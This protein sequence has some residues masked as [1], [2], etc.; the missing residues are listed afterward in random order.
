MKQ[1]VNDI[2]LFIGSN[3]VD[4][5]YLGTDLVYDANPGPPYDAQVEYLQGDGSAYIDTNIAVKDATRVEILFYSPTGSSKT[6]FGNTTTSTS[7]GYPASVWVEGGGVKYYAVGQSA[8]KLGDLNTDVSADFTIPTNAVT[9]S[10]YMF[11]ANNYLGHNG[12]KCYRCKLYNGSE[13]IRDF[14]PVRKD[15]VGYMYDNVSGRLFGNV[16][17]GSFTYGNDV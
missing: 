3:A 17:T 8:V 13:L 6:V 10:I 12:F 14:I 7:S 2:V 16:G 1:G 9:S 5:A 15:N 11:K 4:K